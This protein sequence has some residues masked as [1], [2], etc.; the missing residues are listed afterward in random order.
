M[1]AMQISRLV[2]TARQV[3]VV[4][5]E[6]TFRFSPATE[7][8]KVAEERRYTVYDAGSEAFIT[9]YETQRRDYGKQI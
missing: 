6:E 1:E 8:L 7:E 2:F 4:E 9:S 5:I 3:G